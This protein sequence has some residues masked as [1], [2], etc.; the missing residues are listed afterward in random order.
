MIIEQNV[1]DSLREIEFVFYRVLFYD[2]FLQAT[3][4][5]KLVTYRP[6]NYFFLN[7]FL[8]L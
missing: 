6:N 1:V 3:F 7:N 4:D 5:D 2:L 8:L